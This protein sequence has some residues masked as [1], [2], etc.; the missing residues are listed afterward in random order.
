MTPRKRH[1]HEP[2]EETV[3]PEVTADAVLAHLATLSQPASIRQIAHGMELRHRGRRYLPRV[4]QKLK[5]RREV[6]EIHGGGFR[7]P[8]TEDATKETSGRAAAANPAHAAR[9]AAR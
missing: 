7:P 8:G 5:K 9:A 2:R 3:S 1:S 4:L 6:E